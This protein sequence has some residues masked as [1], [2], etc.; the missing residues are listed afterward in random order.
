MKEE[1]D[2]GF[3]MIELLLVI[4]VLGVLAATVI[5]ALG[6]VT[7]S[8]AQA[9]C[10][11]DAKSLE[12]AVQA[13]HDSSTNTAD[14]NGWPTANAQLT[15]P[16]SSNFG[17]PYV[18]NWPNNN[19]YSIYLGDGVTKDAGHNKTQAG[20]VLVGPS[21]ATGIKDSLPYDALPN[22]CNASDIS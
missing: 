8:A 6:N 18:S 9:S 4:V 1:R 10:N 12:V 19:H 13:F 21:S 5:F 20:E 14:P 2:C 7:G 15:D 17:G 22:P 16:A 3:T 11:S